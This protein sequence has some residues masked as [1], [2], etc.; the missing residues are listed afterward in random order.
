MNINKTADECIIESASVLLKCFVDPTLSVAQKQELT[1]WIACFFDYQDALINDE[2][3]KID[4]LEDKLKS[5]FVPSY[6]KNALKEFKTANLLYQKSLELKDL[7]TLFLKYSTKQT[8]K[9]IN[10]FNKKIVKAMEIYNINLEQKFVKNF[11]ILLYT[12]HYHLSYLFK[13][14]LEK[15]ITTF[16]DIIKT[17]V[18]QKKTNQSKLLIDVILSENENFFNQMPQIQL[19]NF[20][21]QIDDIFQENTNNKKIDTKI[22]S[23]IL[24]PPKKINVSINQLLKDNKIDFYHEIWSDKYVDE[25]KSK[26]LM[27][28]FAYETYFVQGNDNHQTY[29]DLVLKNIIDDEKYWILVHKYKLINKIAKKI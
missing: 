17:K 9:A 8:I 14:K 19:T 21:Y 27:H 10:T 5:S 20:I 23:L 22:K 1:K 16:I 26:L 6:Y 13:T 18:I 7:L 29:E 25:K 24:T 3:N 2:Q 15:T 4:S 12:I 11:Q 28:L